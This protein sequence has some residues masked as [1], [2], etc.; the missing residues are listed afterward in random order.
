LAQTHISENSAGA[1]FEK[2]GLTSLQ[3]VSLVKIQSEPDFESSSENRHRGGGCAHLASSRTNSRWSAQKPRGF[4]PGKR[5]SDL[6]SDPLGGR[7]VRH[8]HQSPSG[9]AKNYEAVE[10]HE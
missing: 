2:E 7:I 6:T 8:A 4:V 10:Q 1:V 3:G 5:V 9:V